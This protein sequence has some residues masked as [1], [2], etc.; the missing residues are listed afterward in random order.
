MRD[1][2]A[3]HETESFSVTDKDDAFTAWAGDVILAQ[4]KCDSEATP[5]ED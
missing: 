1:I 2:A 4:C 5:D 3:I